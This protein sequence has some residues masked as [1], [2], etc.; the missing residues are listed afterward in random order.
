MELS[1]VIF[2]NG[3]LLSCDDRSGIVFELNLEKKIAIPQWI[4]SG[5][6]GRSTDK[7]FKCEWLTVKGD[8]LYVG[9]QGKEYTDND[10]NI[11]NKDNLWVKTVDHE[12]RIKHVNWSDI[13]DSLRKAT[14]TQYPGYLIHEAV[15]WSEQYK[16]WLFLPRRVSK[17]MYDDEKDESRGSNIGLI[18]DEKMKSIKTIEVGEFNQYLGFSSF[19]FI[20]YKENHIVVLK[21]EENG[22]I[23]RTIMYVYDYKNQK[24][25]SPEVLVSDKIKFEGIE[26]L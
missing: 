14:G 5:G 10:G 24:M 13:Y 16:H 9:S 2:F 22:S 21:T 11:I 7:G 18:M 6:D 23:I 26:I 20:P 3:Q 25:L 15:G 1:E 8:K 17:E 12:G 19:K 4:F